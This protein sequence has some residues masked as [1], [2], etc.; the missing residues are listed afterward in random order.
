MIQHV[1]NSK[2]AKAI[3]SDRWHV[4]H[5]RFIRLN[6]KWRFA[7]GVHS[8]HGDVA[9]CKT[10]AKALLERIRTEGSKLPPE[11]RDEVFV[12]RPNYKTL[13]TCNNRR[14]PA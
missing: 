12:R 7:R 6:G 9:E 11:E 8:E 3:T 2:G 5:S 13:E 4:V 14:R 10:A 1:V